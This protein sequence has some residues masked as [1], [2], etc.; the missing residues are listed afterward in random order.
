MARHERCRVPAHEH[1]NGGLGQRA[2][3]IVEQR[4]GEHD[5]A[6]PAQLNEEDAFDT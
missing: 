1:V 5:V 2:M 6:Q 3:Q 4:R